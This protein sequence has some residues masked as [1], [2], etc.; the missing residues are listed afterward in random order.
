M[1]EESRPDPEALLRRLQ[2]KEQKAERRAGELKIFVGAAAG[3][4][5]TY[6]M[7]E[8]AQSL[9][10][11]GVDVVIALVE[12]HGRHETELLL[13]G[14]EIIPRLQI[15]HG[16]IT[17]EEMD[18]DG[19]LARRPAIALV[20]EL[21]H[22][23]APGTRHAKRHQDVEELLDAGI[24]VYTT[25]NIQ[26]AESLNDI[27]YQITGIR[28]RETV[29]DRILQM[30]DQLEVVDLPPD[31]LLARFNEG[32]VYVPPKAEQAVRR[33]FRKGNLLGLREMVLRYTARK[34]DDDM[35]SYMDRHGILGPWPAGSRLLVCIST[36]SLSERLV[37]IGQRMA[38][39][40]NAE[41][42]AVYVESPLERQTARSAQDQLARNMRLAEEL[43]AKVQV[44]SGHAISEEILSFAR[45]Q[46][47]TLMVVGLPRRRLWN[48][49]L[50]GS[51]VN[52]IISRSGPIHVLVIGS[53]EAEIKEKE[54]TRPEPDEV[55]SWRPYYG[56]LAS[57]ATVTAF[58]WVLHPW[59]G[60]INTAMMLLLPVVYSGITWGRR[61]GLAASVLAVAA[62]DFFFV[63]PQL[64]LAVEDL[65]YL[66]MFFVF[67]IVGIATS[68]VADLVRWQGEN[69]RQRERFVSAL[70]AFS[71]DLMAAEDQGSLLRYA[72]KE[73]AEAFRCEVMILLPDFNGKLEVRAQMGEHMIFDE[74]K[75]GVATWVFEHDQPAGRGTETLSSASLFYLPLHAKEVTVGVMGVSLG[76]PERLLSPE[77]RRLLESFASIIALTVARTV[78]TYGK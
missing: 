4:G 75:L 53:T 40:L 32:K 69:A 27:V 25:M 38:A 66:P 62:L 41:W 15:E 74:R 24:S 65:R 28:V 76:A 19:V 22:T 3:V 18:L 48:R 13:E 9:K 72:A 61:A 63:P 6:Q 36:S 68:F 64:N 5:K 35:R 23:N 47:I 12:T 58:C 77:Q 52:E 57:V 44:L 11:D 67:F 50:S 33:F 17:L 7:L 42:F 59:L 29:P 39:D 71:R 2:Q 26:H 56:S 30:A 21:A 16:G 73:I 45:A 70:Y 14:Q 34:V 31:E 20:D 8:E 46:N 10:K 51:V 1:P 49:W 37:R 60:L 54:L 55:M 78:G 43:G